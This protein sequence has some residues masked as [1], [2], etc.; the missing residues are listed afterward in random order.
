M[1]RALLTIFL[2]AA[3]QAKAAYCFDSEPGDLLHLNKIQSVTEIDDAFKTTR[4][5][6]TG[7]IESETMEYSHASL[8]PSSIQSTYVYTD[9]GRLDRID[10]TVKQGRTTST[11]REVIE[12][13]SQG[14]PTRVLNRVSPSAPFQVEVT[15]TYGSSTITEVIAPSD[16]F[17][18]STQVYYLNSA[19]QLTR[20]EQTLKGNEGK[21]H[22]TT[23][24]YADG[25]LRRSEERDASGDIPLSITIEEYNDDGFITSSSSK[26]Y[27]EK[28][29]LFF[30]TTRIYAYNLDQLGNWVKQTTYVQF[31][32]GEKKIENTITRVIKYDTP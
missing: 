8:P 27:N 26:D 24:T 22:A 7:R 17:R 21:E 6:K 23:Y 4:R 31:N 28:N 15:C 9:S 20:L 29:E 1:K 13:D 19:G 10:S 14:R 16:L 11:S 18:G 3:S 2:L 25:R 12:Y 32:S 5:F 30:Q